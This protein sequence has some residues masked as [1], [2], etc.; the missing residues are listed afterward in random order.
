MAES[1]AKS[2]AWT[3]EVRDL[4]EKWQALGQSYLSGLDQ[5]TQ[6]PGASA[7]QAG[8]QF[9]VGQELLNTWRG[10]WTAAGDAQ[11]AAVDRFAEVLA[12]L[13]AIGP[14]REHTETW[15]E[16]AAAQAE[17]QRLEQELRTVL[18]GVQSDALNLLQQRVRER[19]QKNEPLASYRDFY[20]LW[21]ECAEL[22]YSKVVHSDTYC[23]L[24]GE[25]GN[26]SMRLR[27]HQQKV[28]ERGLKQ[29]DLP[30]RSELNT[31]HRQLR[32]QKQQLREQKQQIADLELS[33]RQA[34]AAPTRKRPAP[35]GK[36]TRKRAAASGKT[37]KSR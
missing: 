15:R 31:V 33:L 23:K 1:E 2:G 27:S 21:V 12:R 5:Y 25:L 36:A 26:A 22:V 32:E 14:V 18:L 3:Q 8:A 28:I 4:A 34:S 11:Q 20:N 19:D 10:A 6:Q 17:C 30:T 29:F 37:G 13:P 7:G 9:K 24:Q 35:A 16:L